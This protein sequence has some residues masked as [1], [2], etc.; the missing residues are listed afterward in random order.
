MHDFSKSFAFGKRLP[1][2]TTAM[3]GD[4]IY[5]HHIRKNKKILNQG[6]LP[7]Y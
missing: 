5:G 4:W 2:K 3:L 1:L 6:M 7:S